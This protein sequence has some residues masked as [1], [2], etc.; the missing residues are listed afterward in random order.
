M[1]E[2][3]GRL[4][5]LPVLEMHAAHAAYRAGFLPTVGGMRQQSWAF[6]SSVRLLETVHGIHEDIETERRRPRGRQ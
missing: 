4:L 1:T 2:C 6:V 3:P 5:T